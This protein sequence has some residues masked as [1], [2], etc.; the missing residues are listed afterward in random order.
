MAYFPKNKAKVKPAKE[1]DY[2][3]QDD[4]TPF[5]GNYI[6]TSKNRYY[7][8]D[9]INSPGRVII[10]TEARK[11]KNILLNYLKNLLL[12]ALTELAK[13]LLANL[14]TSLL[15]NLINPGDKLIVEQ[16]QE[17]LDDA[18]GRDLTEQEQNEI[19][20]LL[21]QIESEEVELDNTV[22][23]NS[24]YNNLKPGIFK[25]LNQNKSPIST[26][27]RPK[28]TDYSNGSYIRYFAKRN[29]SLNKYFEIDKSIYDSIS[30]N[31]TK[32]DINLYQV[33][34]IKWSLGENA[35]EINTNIITRYERFLLGIKNLF[36]D[37]TEYAQVI[38]NNLYTEGNELYFENGTEYIGEYHVH[39]INGPMVGPIHIEEPHSNLYYSYELGTSK[40]DPS[41]Q[42]DISVDSQS[43]LF[44]TIGYNEYYIKSSKFGIYCEVLD[45]LASPDSVIYTSDTFPRSVTTREA[46]VNE[47]MI[48]IKQDSG[49]AGLP[50]NYYVTITNVTDKALKKEYSK[51]TFATAAVGNFKEKLKN[52][53][54]IGSSAVD[55][56][57][58]LK[59]EQDPSSSGPMAFGGGGKVSISFTKLPYRRYGRLR[60]EEAFAIQESLTSLGIE[61]TILNR[62]SEPDQPSTFEEAFDQQSNLKSKL[63]VGKS[64]GKS[65]SGNK[66][67]S[68]RGG[69]SR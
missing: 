34:S 11:T 23:S 62:W 6:Q 36:S 43:E 14:L 46:L 58:G 20:N 4:K 10:P 47:A 21:D 69:Y 31:K 64:T 61:S 37:P 22:I 56:A 1:G 5:S 59:V 51:M 42:N 66:A 3:Y 60:K 7:E 45:T 24:I 29:N 49:D 52:T 33:F 13:K 54:D 50:P 39:P 28:D 19:K 57:M 25:K 55:V 15:K 30:Q 68:G 32:F 17:I 63:L 40:S 12:F 53:V 9:D 48:T 65:S 38:K 8:G 41:T 35:K 26:K 44:K 2:I 16:A 67:P 27:I 18:E